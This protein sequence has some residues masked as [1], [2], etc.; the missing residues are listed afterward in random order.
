MAIVGTPAVWLSAELNSKLAVQW[1]CEFAASVMCRHNPSPLRVRRMGWEKQKTII[2]VHPNLKSV[3][4]S[5][6]NR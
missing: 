3:D 2:E 1:V 6:R 5:T 4:K